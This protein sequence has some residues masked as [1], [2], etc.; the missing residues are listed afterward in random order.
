MSPLN[1]PDSVDL[2]A[3]LRADVRPSD[4]QE[5]LEGHVSVETRAEPHISLEEFDGDEVVVRVAATP[6]RAAEGPQLADEILAAVTDAATRSTTP[7]PA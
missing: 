1:E 6:V 3:R 2:R 4:L 5:L 7:T